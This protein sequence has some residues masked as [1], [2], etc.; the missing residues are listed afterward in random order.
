MWFLGLRKKSYKIFKGKFVWSNKV[1]GAWLTWR[2]R[3]TTVYAVMGI[4]KQLANCLQ[5]GKR[6]VK[7]SPTAAHLGRKEAWTSGALDNTARCGKKMLNNRIS[8]GRTIP[9]IFRECEEVDAGG[10][11]KI[12]LLA[13][14]LLNNWKQEK[15]KNKKTP[16]L[17]HQCS[18]FMHIHR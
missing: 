17:T 11:F 8:R 9:L 14:V 3:E 2:L 15:T 10:V 7:F 12:S 16:K 18:I 4:F 1:H 13:G 6:H 5:T